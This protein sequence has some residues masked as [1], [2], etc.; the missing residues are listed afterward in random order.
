MRFSQS[1]VTSSSRGLRL[2]FLG[3]CIGLLGFKDISEGA[4]DPLN[5]PAVEVELGEEQII[6]R[7]AGW[8]YLFQA[9]EGT[10]I[11]LG[12]RR[13]IP[14][15]PEPIVFTLRSFDGRK[16]WQE[17]QPSPQQGPGPVTEGTAVQLK[18]GRILI[19]DVYAYHQG[20][21]Q[22]KGKRWVST[23]G[24]RTVNGPES[25]HVSVP[26]ALTDGMVDDRGEPISRLSLRRSALV[27][28]NGDLLASAYGRFEGDNTSV[29]YIPAMKQSRSYLLRSKD[30]GLTW[31][32][33]GTIAPPPVGQEGFGEPV[34]IQLQRGPHAGRLLCQMRVGREH[35]VYQTESDDEGQTW[36]TPHALSW[37]YSRFGRQREIIGV[38][39]DLTEMSNG[40]LV[41]GYG[42]KPDYR[43]DGNFLAFSVDSGVTWTEE[44]RI[45]TGLT[46]AYVGVRETAPETLFV[47]YTKTDETRPW[48]YKGA[49]FNTYGRSVTVKPTQ[50]SSSSPGR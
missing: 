33:A 28:K 39:P 31:T 4:I 18:D 16:T 17:W 30:E 9:A 13:W 35:A 26:Q 42:H 45:S 43:D 50:S 1:S 7:D 5:R 44:T 8:P 37:T 38:D 27:L 48:K 34:L 11:V 23:D 36:S 2:A 10:T 29:E 41:M 19:F 20:N 25:I 12:H 24:W 21:K 47:V 22:F 32:Y 46:L 6:T 3:V 49:T 40:V 14:R 15:Q